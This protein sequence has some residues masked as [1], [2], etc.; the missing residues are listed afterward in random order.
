MAH[1]LYHWNQFNEH[2]FILINKFTNFGIFPYILQQ[3][4]SIFFIGNFV[5]AYI[6]ACIFCYFKIRNSTNRSHEF[7][8]N[9]QELTRIGTCY[10]LFG[11]TFAALKFSVNLP[12]PFCSLADNEFV[13]I[14]NLSAERCLSSFPSAHTGLA[15]LITYCLWPHMNKF[16][17]LLAGCIVILVALSRITLAMHYPADIIYSAIVTA[18]VI[19]AGN[20][21]H[22]L[23]KSN[24]IT[25]IGKFIFKHLFNN[26]K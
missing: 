8:Q 9:Y 22:S 2:L 20:G 4:S 15:L 18:I 19:I 21:I 1:S 25:P 10:A 17:K 26:S 3:L 6:L 12:R 5:I 11:F 23:A 14:A 13:T 7:Y 24:I 16:Y